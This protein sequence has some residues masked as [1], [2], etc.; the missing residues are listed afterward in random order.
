MRKRRATASVPLFS[1]VNIPKV[2]RPLLRPAVPRF[3]V[4]C[5]GTWRRVCDLAYSLL[6]VIRSSDVFL[7][8][9]GIG[10]VQAQAFA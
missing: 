8:P 1:V 3:S 5:V 9:I 4:G 2:P 6:S 7:P 10:G